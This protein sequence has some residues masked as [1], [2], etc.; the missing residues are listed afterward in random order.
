VGGNSLGDDNEPLPDRGVRDTPKDL[1][2]KKSNA[3]VEVPDD[4]CGRLKTRRAGR[5]KQP[6]VSHRNEEREQGKFFYH[7][8]VCHMQNSAD[9]GVIALRVQV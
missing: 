6:S 3:P 5:E 4:N 7:P 8:G 2:S 1:T 9:R